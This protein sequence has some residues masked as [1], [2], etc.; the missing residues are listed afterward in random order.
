LYTLLLSTDFFFPHAPS[1]SLSF[2]HFLVASNK[3]RHVCTGVVPGF[4]V[5]WIPNASPQKGQKLTDIPNGKVSDTV[6]FVMPLILTFSW[7]CYSGFRADNRY[8][9]P[10]VNHKHRD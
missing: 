5:V 4:D 8:A 9:K 3:I 7:K 2:P 6:F 10:K 1:P